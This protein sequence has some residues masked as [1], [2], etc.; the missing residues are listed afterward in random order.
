MLSGS[1]IGVPKDNGS[2]YIKDGDLDA[3]WNR[4]TTHAIQFAL[5]GTRVACLADN[6][7]AFAKQG[8]VNATQWTTEADHVTEIALS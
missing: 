8:A 5:S 1:H 7:T 6:G 2:V 4:Q 3:L